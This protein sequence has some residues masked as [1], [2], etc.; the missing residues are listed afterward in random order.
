M[1]KHIVMFR[2]KEE[3]EGRTKEENIQR[4]V[5]ILKGLKDKIPV[6][7]YL[8][9]GVNKGSSRSASDVVLYT[10]FD[11]MEDLAIY[12]NHPEHQKAVD[13]IENVCTERRVIDY[14]P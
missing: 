5:D 8:E 10:E 4:L 6:V 12:R 2:M 1:L 11:S 3:A 9:V 7:R 14:E 13:F